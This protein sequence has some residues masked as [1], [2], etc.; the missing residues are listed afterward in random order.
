MKRKEDGC[1]S[2]VSPSK[3]EETEYAKRN[4]LAG[5]L[6]DEGWLEKFV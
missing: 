1:S 4:L 5:D 2:R 3:L 6:D